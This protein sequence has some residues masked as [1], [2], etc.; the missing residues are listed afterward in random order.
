MMRSLTVLALASLATAVFGFDGKDQRAVPLPQQAEKQ[1]DLPDGAVMRLGTSS[2]RHH[3][4]KI[5]AMAITGDRQIL[6]TSGQDGLCKLWDTS[7]GKLI[8]RYEIDRPSS[9]G[10]DGEFAMSEDGKLLAVAN[11]NNVPPAIQ[12]FDVKSGTQKMQLVGHMKPITSVAFSP[13]GSKLASLS[14]DKTLRLW[15]VATGKLLKALEVERSMYRSW[16][17]FSPN[18]KLL[19]TSGHGSKSV[20]LWDVKKGHRKFQLQMEAASTPS[21]DFSS[22]SRLLVSGTAGAIYFWDSQTGKTAEPF[23]PVNVKIGSFA[24]QA[25]D[26]TLAWADEKTGRISFLDHQMHRPLTDYPVFE[27]ATYSRLL[28]SRDGNLLIGSSGGRARLWHV[29]QGVEVAQSCGHRG[30]I[31]GI[32]Y[33]PDGRCVVTGSEDGSLRAWDAATGKEL[34]QFRGHG[35]WVSN[36]ACSP[37]GK[38]L[39]A[40]GFHD[41]TVSVWEF[42]SA[43]LL[44]RLEGY[45]AAAFT[46]DGKRLVTGHLDKSIRIWDPVTGRQTHRLFADQAAIQC[47][48]VS[49][50]G[51]TLAHGDAAGTLLVW[52]LD[53]H[54]V[55]HRIRAH[56][57]I[58]RTVTFSPDGKQIATGGDDRR[59][60][61]WDAADGSRSGEIQTSEPLNFLRFSPG[62]KLVLTVGASGKSCELWN[63][64]TYRRLA[65]VAATRRN[66]DKVAIS[67]DA[68]RL[69]TSADGYSVLIWDLKALLGR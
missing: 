54:K 23:R 10:L 11:P 67:P 7:T 45:A 61:F 37:D 24:L 41:Q 69:A 9:G 64:T 15:N 55:R 42:A 47:L 34:R 44:H 33:S 31:F 59:V 17:R 52:N 35:G 26:R 49:P 21:L 58:V 16:M 18:G 68:K 20:S 65:N 25:D 38:M 63:P 43:K 30:R 60:R 2:F 46:P 5:L 66:M 6:A 4:G 53:N 50:D 22:D 13:D 36:V 28:F 29:K 3:F 8:G 14:H 12:L 32:I 51:K 57:G 40:A 1:A 62:G 48:A 19:A 39:A 56:V 27:R